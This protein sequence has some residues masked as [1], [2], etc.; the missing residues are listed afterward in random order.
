MGLVWVVD[1]NWLGVVLCMLECDK[2]DEVVK[3]ECGRKDM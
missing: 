2:S 1:M 3:G